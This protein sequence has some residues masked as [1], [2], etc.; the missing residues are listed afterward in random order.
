MKT[1]SQYYFNSIS[2][3]DSLPKKD[4]ILFK[5]NMRLHRVK[6]GKELFKEGS[7]PKVIYIIKRGMVKLFQQDQ[8]G[9]EKIVYIYTPGEM[10]GYRPSL[11]DEKHPATAITMEDGAVYSLPVENFQAVLAESAA[12]SN[13]LLKNLSHE[14]TVLVNRI[15]AFAQ[16]S[17]KERTA[18]S[19]LILREKFRKPGSRNHGDIIMSRKDLAAFVGTT[20]E[21]LARIVTQFKK[22]RVIMTYSKRI[23][24]LN[25]KA[26]IQLAE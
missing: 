20:I 6:K 9:S 22:D 16:K 5:S 3:F 4:L 25:E 12:L 8:D 15:G 19:I 14:F 1:I 26:L 2:V 10:F 13:I 23:I 18:L 21:T 7:Y 17:A 24:V 11:C